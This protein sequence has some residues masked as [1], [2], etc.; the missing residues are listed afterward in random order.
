V[1]HRES[2]GTSF[3]VGLSR[4]SPEAPICREINVSTVAR[5]LVGVFPR[6]VILC[7]KSKRLMRQIT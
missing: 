5:G 3:C 1:I 6:E 4:A 2:S 7:F